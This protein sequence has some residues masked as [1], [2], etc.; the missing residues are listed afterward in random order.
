[1]L[2]V[3]IIL[4]QFAVVFRPMGN[5]LGTIEIL[6]LSPYLGTEVGEPDSKLFIIVFCPK[7]KLLIQ[8]IKKTFKK[9]KISVITIKI[10]NK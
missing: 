3:L 7:T 10:E 1:M 8:Q 6:E 5:G 2:I 4:A 9:V